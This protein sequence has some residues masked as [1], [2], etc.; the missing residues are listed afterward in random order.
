MKKQ[1]IHMDGKSWNLAQWSQEKEQ[2][3]AAEGQ[4]MTLQQAHAI[5]QELCQLSQ[6]PGLI[7]R[8]HAL[9]H[10]TK[11]ATAAGNVKM[12]IG[13]REPDA[14]RMYSL[15][16]KICHSGLTQLLLVRVRPQTYGGAL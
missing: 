9:R 7:L 11:V 1:L 16:K 4:R 2:L 5:I 14:G 13:H 12:V 15:L 8:F 10:L 6:K 3:A